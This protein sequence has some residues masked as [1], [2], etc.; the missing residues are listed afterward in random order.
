M[1]IRV[2][3]RAE[4]YPLRLVT[5]ESPQSP[6]R[7]ATDIPVWVLG[8][9]KHLGESLAQPASADHSQGRLLYE[10]FESAR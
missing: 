4:Q 7:P 2:V 9:A 8:E 5:A 3:E 1:D 10:G 6:E